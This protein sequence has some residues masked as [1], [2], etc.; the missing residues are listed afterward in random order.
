[1]SVWHVCLYEY[2]SVCVCGMCLCVY[3]LYVSVCMWHVC[4]CVCMCVMYAYIYVCLRV[5]YIC[6]CVVCVYK[7][8]CISL[9]VWCIYVCMCVCKCVFLCVYVLFVVYAHLYYRSLR[10]SDVT[11]AVFLC[12]SPPYSLESGS[13]P[14][15]DARLAPAGITDPPVSPQHMAMPSTPVG[16]GDLQSGLH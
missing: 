12:H 15:S 11:S 9:C 8:A 14:E 5:V 4:F 7:Y 2:V 3:V 13:L 1:M 6:V 10:R 16:A